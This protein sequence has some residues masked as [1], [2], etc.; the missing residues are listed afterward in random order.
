[1]TKLLSLLIAISC[2]SAPA[3]ARDDGGFGATEFPAK[4][5]AALGDYVAS[6]FDEV[7]DPSKIEPAAGE[8]DI[9][10]ESEIL[11]NTGTATTDTAAPVIDTPDTKDA[12]QE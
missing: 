4:A 10:P 7:T 3:W 5:P 6:S 1:M 11:D 2:L 9:Q 8:E 12:P